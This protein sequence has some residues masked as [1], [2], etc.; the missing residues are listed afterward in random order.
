MLDPGPVHDVAGVEHVGGVLDERLEVEVV[1]VDQHHDRVGRGVRSRRSPPEWPS[2]AM[3]RTSLSPRA[4]GR[5][6]FQLSGQ[7]A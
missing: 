3:R 4:A 7:R 1:V 2:A 6:R 5:D